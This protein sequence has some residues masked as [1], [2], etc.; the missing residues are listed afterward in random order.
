M[1]D[2]FVLDVSRICQQVP[3]FLLY[4]AISIELAKS[5]IWLTNPSGKATH[6]C[7]TVKRTE[8][9]QLLSTDKPRHLLPFEVLMIELCTVPK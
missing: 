6:L 9:E 5:V 2:H 3:T 4:D 7:E 8:W 1:L